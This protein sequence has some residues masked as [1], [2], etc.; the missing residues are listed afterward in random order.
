MPRIKQHYRCSGQ[1]L[2]KLRVLLHKWWQDHSL[3]GG[4]RHKKDSYLSTAMLFGAAFHLHIKTAASFE[5]CLETICNLWPRAFAENN[6]PAQKIV[7]VRELL[8]D[9]DLRHTFF[10]LT[11]H[12][13]TRTTFDSPLSPSFIYEAFSY[14]DRRT[15][16]DLLQDERKLVDA[17]HLISFTQVYTPHW[18]VDH[19]L[20]KTLAKIISEQ[21]LQGLTR[22][23]LLDPALGGGVFLVQ[24]LELLVSAY[25]DFGLSDY[26]AASRAL[27]HNLYGLDI[28]P[29][30]LATAALTLILKLLSLGSSVE[31]IRII[32]PFKNLHLLAD[33]GEGVSEGLGSLS[34][35][36][37]SRAGHPLS[38]RYDVVVA[39]PPY[40]GRKLLP[41]ALKDKLKRHYP[42]A[43]S[44]LSQAFLSMA[45]DLTVAG[46]M[47]GFITQQSLLH[48][49]NARSLRQR[50]L[51]EHQLVE[52][53]ELGAGVFP[54]LPGEKAFTVLVTICKL[55]PEGQEV[56]SYISLVADS[57]KE[58]SLK[59]CSAAQISRA[60]SD[61]LKDD[62]LVINFHR[63]QAVL[64]LRAT[65]TK[66]AD[67]A[68]LKQ[69]LATTDNG[70][71][72]RHIWEVPASDIPGRYVPYARGEGA[73]RWWSPVNTLVLWQD[74]GRA[75]KEAV[76][77][78]YPY[79]KGNFAWVVKNEDYYF[80]PGLTFSFVS[81]DRLAVRLLPGGAIFDVGSSAIFTRDERH[82][83]AILAYLNSSL[84]TAMAHDLNPTINFQVG[85]LKKLVI[86]DFT[87][88][89][90][91]RLGELAEICIAAKKEKFALTAPVQF[92]HDRQR[93]DFSRADFE[94][95]SEALN[96]AQRQ[97]EESEDEIDELVL[98]TI[99]RETSLSRADQEHIYDFCRRPKPKSRDVF[100]E[101]KYCL[102][103]LLKSMLKYFVDQ[104]DSAVI[105]PLRHEND[106]RQFLAFWLG[107]SELDFAGKSLDS[108][109]GLSAFIRT[110]LARAF[111]EY[112]ADQPPLLVIAPGQA[113]V[114]LPPQ[115]LHAPQLVAH[116]IED[117]DCCRQAESQL[118]EA[119]KNGRSAMMQ[120]IELR[121]RE[122][123]KQ[124]SRTV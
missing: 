103:R 14:E 22:K 81:K 27:N 89:E 23:R 11:K 1:E 4:G 31:H 55:P 50:I 67:V 107:V 122:I 35:E 60:Q 26:E 45:L 48:L 20:Q 124:L 68:T 102:S 37:R 32:L 115:Q 30:A 121:P 77:E 52:V 78:A 76:N 106:A 120:D 28:D 105:A 79:L 39:N 116:T 108:G 66:L 92:F 61:F 88:A 42:E 12:R 83:L 117:A 104:P 123:L 40:L 85:D 41:R 112:F 63:P 54:M 15:S 18:V 82:R 49:A 84:A 111:D 86:P 98:Q 94:L 93:S 2:R 34:R 62:Q 58:A 114:V 113:I 75:I 109:K 100:D 53:V 6:F 13:L 17:S 46:G 19:L 57:D 71:F 72:L 70:R 21:D 80:R 38:L 25:K 24:A 51:K 95:T 101:Q 8:A 9:E 99:T 16:K 56:C 64:H 44:D 90:L 5:D 43:A 97:L 36:L 10:Q 47:I 7:F 87:G 118:L 33:D 3:A 91:S 110:A 119:G 96:R 59:S 74:N 69:G 29:G 65:M 73:E